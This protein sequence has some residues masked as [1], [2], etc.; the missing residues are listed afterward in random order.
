VERDVANTVVVGLS[1]RRLNP[2][3]NDAI[4]DRVEAVHDDGDGPCPALSGCFSTGDRAVPSEF[5]H[6]LG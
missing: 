6:L 4:H 3:G 2:H 1:L 5:P